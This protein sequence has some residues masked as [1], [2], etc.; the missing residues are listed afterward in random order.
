MDKNIS[1][2]GT[3]CSKCHCLE[4]KMCNG[5]NASQGIVFH[6]GNKE[7]AIYACCKKDSFDNCLACAKIPC[8]IWRKTRDPRFTDEEFEKSI[9]ERINLLKEMLG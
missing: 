1:I 7:C 6:T 8:D 3:D 4:S 9:N 5:C 2:C